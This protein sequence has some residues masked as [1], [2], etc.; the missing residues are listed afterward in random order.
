MNYGWLYILIAKINELSNWWWFLGVSSQNIGVFTF[1]M[2]LL[3][4]KNICQKSKRSQNH[5]LMSFNSIR[6]I[7][8]Y[9]LNHHKSMHGVTGE[10]FLVF[11]VKLLLFS[12]SICFCLIENSFLQVKKDLK[13]IYLWASIGLE[14]WLDKYYSHQSKCMEW[15]LMV[16]WCLQPNHYYIHI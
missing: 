10:S 2:L 7:A 5:L 15:L 13:L 4:G 12:V 14:L 11:P 1:N 8:G 16:A 6:I 3:N 9:I